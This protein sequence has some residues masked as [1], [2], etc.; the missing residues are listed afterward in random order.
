MN[1]LRTDEIFDKLI[2]E[3][4][5]FT[6]EIYTRDYIRKPTISGKDKLK[7]KCAWK[8]TMIFNYNSP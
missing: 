3:A 6:P 7:L 2:T 8:H 5:K 4:K 1:T